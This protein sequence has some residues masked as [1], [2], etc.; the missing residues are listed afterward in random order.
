[1]SGSYCCAEA[2]G[3]GGLHDLAGRE[4]CLMSAAAA[5]KALE[6]PSVGVPMFMAIAAGTGEPI[7]AQD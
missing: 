1:M 6:P 2:C 3:L 7:T 5:L 4:R